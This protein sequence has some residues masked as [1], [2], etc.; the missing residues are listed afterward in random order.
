MHLIGLSIPAD[1]MSLIVGVS[2][3]LSITE[4]QLTFD[5]LTEFFVGWAKSPQQQRPLNILYMAPWLANLQSQVLALDG[6]SEKGKERLANLARKLIEITVN[7]T[8][9]YTL[10]QQNVWSVI[11]K[12]ESLLEVFF[13]E[14]MKSAMNFGF[15]SA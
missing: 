14:L 8:N 11:S 15:G 5:F 7:E 12:D 6:D 2:E 13:E 3:K 1:S 9:L 4:P 10:F